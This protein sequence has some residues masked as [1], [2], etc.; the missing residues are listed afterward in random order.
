M[1]FPLSKLGG[2]VTKGYLSGTNRRN[3]ID[4]FRFI[5]A[6]GARPCHDVIRSYISRGKRKEVRSPRFFLAL[7]PASPLVTCEPVIGESCYLL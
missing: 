7:V 5:F 6:T 3:R 2:H 4:Y 1:E